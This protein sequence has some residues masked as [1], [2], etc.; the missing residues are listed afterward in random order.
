LFSFV[1]YRPHADRDRDAKTVI[2]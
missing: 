1:S 2:L